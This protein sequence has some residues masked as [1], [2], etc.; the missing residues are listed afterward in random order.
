MTKVA[1]RARN[2]QAEQHLQAAG[3]SVLLARLLAARGVT[4]P[5]QLSINLGQLL[6]PDTLTNNATM[7][8]LLADAILGN[9]KLLVI[10]DYDAD[11]ATATAVAVK[12]LQAFI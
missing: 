10:G 1:H 8:K 7:A 4:E 3:V 12:G 2:S 5:A 6:P 11:G 9:K